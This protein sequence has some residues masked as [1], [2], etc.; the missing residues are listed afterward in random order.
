[1]ARQAIQSWLAARR[2]AARKQAI[3]DYAAEQAGTELDLDRSLEAA[4]VEF[5]LEGKPR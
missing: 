1:M 3:A 4:T 5:L 2:K